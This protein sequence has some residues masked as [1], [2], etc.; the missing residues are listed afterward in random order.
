MLGL[1][2]ECSDL[3]EVR[4]ASWSGQT[5]EAQLVGDVLNFDLGRRET[6]PDVN[7]VEVE[8]QAY[9]H[10]RRF[11]GE[12]GKERH[13]GPKFNIIARPASIAEGGFEIAVG[14]VLAAR[15]K[16]D[17]VY[18]GVDELFF[19]LDV[20]QEVVVLLVPAAVLDDTVGIGRSGPANVFK[21][22]RKQV[23]I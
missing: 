21:S 6:G 1:T 17:G 5:Q 20:G 11:P 9:H 15:L 22:A 7:N 14:G 10:I 13:R 3:A 18:K 16:F 4:E 19:R 12:T 2:E 8:E 23:Y